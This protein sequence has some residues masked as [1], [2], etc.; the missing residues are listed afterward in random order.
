VTI[1]GSNF[2]GSRTSLSG[3]GTTTPSYVTFDGTAATGYSDWSDSSVTVVVPPAARSGPVRVVTVRGE[4]NDDRSFTVGTPTWFLAEGSTKWGFDTYISIENPNRSGVKARITYMTEDGERR[5]PQV[6]LPGYSQTTVNPRDDLGDLDFSTKV[7]CTTE[8]R[9]IA[10]DRTMSWTGPGAPSPEGHSSIGVTAPARSWYLPEGSSKWGFEC[11]LLLQ[12]PSEDDA[13]VELTYMIEGEGPRV[14]NKEV[15]ANSRRTCDMSADIGAKDASIMVRSDVPVIPERSMYR[16]DR[17]EGHGSIGTTAPAADYYLA[18]GTTDYGFTTYILVQNPNEVSCTVSVTFMTITGPVSYPDFEMPP[19]SRKTIRV[20][21]VMGQT[22][23]S[24][25]VRGSRPIIAERAMYWGAGS[26]LGEAC[27]DSIGMTEP[28]MTFYLPDGETSNGRETY[29][30]VQN[31]FEQDVRIRV[32]YFGGPTGKVS[33]DDTVA[34]YSRKTFDLRGAIEDSRAAIMVG[35]LE[36]GKPIM[37]ERAMY[38]NDR[39]AGTDT[40]G[41]FSD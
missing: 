29:V 15:P 34:G 11:W 39:G 5:M 23:F 13:S 28:H 1:T 6:S 17:R 12:N 24:T 36:P 10:V 19:E 32:T 33:F 7:E 14:V 21:D 3:A 30:L 26:A 35:S 8:G 4:S 2:G 9:S 37:V 38:W 27:H 31:P 22:D 20:N 18:E 25:Q 40:I 41:G 16:N